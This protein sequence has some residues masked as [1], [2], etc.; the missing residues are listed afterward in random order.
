[1][2]AA[3]VI[4]RASTVSAPAASMDT[5]MA[6]L[7]TLEF[8]GVAR[9]RST[10]IACGDTTYFAVT[11]KMISS[12]S[13]MSTN[14]VTLMPVIDPSSSALAPPAMVCPSMLATKKR[15]PRDALSPLY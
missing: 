3:S 12:T 7:T 6:A 14:G 1:M 9:G 8:G 2:S 4:G 13:A 15:A 5:A 10:G 11:M